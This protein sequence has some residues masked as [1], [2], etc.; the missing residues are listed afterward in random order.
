LVETVVDLWP[1]ENRS[2]RYDMILNWI[3]QLSRL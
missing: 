1:K 2:T 3:E